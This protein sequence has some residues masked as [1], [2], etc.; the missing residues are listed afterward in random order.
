KLNRLSR[1]I[2]KM[3][4]YRA[5][6]GIGAYQTSDPA[7]ELAVRLGG[8]VAHG[9]PIRDRNL[10]A[11]GPWFVTKGVVLTRR[12][13]ALPERRAVDGDV[14]HRE[15]TRAHP[16]RISDDHLNQVSGPLP[17][18]AARDRGGQGERICTANEEV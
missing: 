12:D 18:S 1:S 6:R 11:S 3:N 5:D 2:T 9:I 7:H 17:C 8:Q 4:F 14:G 16:A 13:E 10:T 15:G